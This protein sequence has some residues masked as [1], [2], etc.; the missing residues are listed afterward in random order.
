M[1]FQLLCLWALAKCK[2]PLNKGLCY[3]TNLS[4]TT[5]RPILPHL[6]IDHGCSNHLLVNDLHRNVWHLFQ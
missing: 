1:L 3:V 5:I 4:I 6:K 2:E